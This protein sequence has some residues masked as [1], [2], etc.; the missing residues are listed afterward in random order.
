MSF[1]FIQIT[2]HHLRETEAMLTFGFSPGYAFRAVLRH[3]AQHA[4]SRADF[5]VSTGDLV[6]TG[7][8]AEYANFKRVV[9]LDHGQ[10]ASIAPQRDPGRGAS[11]A[12]QRDPGR[13]ATLAP[14][15]QPVTAEGLER[16]PMLFLPGNHDPRPEFSRH[17]YPHLPPSRLFNAV[18]EHQGTRLVCL[19]WGPGVKA[20][21]H[22]ETLRFL[23]ESLADGA[24][25]VLLMH[26]H[27]WPVGARWLDT[28]IMEGVDAFWE[29]VRGKNVL[30][31]L[32][33]HC[34]MTYER[35]VEGIPVL[36]LRATTFQ[37]LPQDPPV[38]CLQPPHY[39]IVTVDGERLTSEIVEVA[40]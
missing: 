29:T 12:P 10:G 21:A 39:R 23:A 30:G 15:P 1:S 3:I 9:G 6:H 25:C 4:A 16:Y 11:V 2:D 13:G 31:I 19:D 7:T 20:M 26:H 37:F 18:Y 24:P 14:M 17:I 8:A 32:C 27:V 35:V 34:H 33:G 38:F 28:F 5:L 22:R 36:G 40:L